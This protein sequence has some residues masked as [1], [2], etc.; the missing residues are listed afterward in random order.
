MAYDRRAELRSGL[1][2]KPRRKDN[3]L[4]GLVVVVVLI[5]F[6]VLASRSGSGSPISSISDTSTA[7]LLEWQEGQ[8]PGW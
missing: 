2:A 5:L 3:L 1:E 6:V 4:I 7:P 8:L